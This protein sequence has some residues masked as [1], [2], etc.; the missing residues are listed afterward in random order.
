[1]TFD[2]DFDYNIPLFSSLL[3]KGRR[4]KLNVLAKINMFVYIRGFC[5]WTP[6]LK[7][8]FA[9]GADFLYSFE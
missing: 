8:R 3:K 9:F 7:S 2:H 5:C 4:R 6:Q 1:M